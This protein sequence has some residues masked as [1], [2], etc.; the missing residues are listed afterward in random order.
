MPMH[1]CGPRLANALIALTVLCTIA[2]TADAASVEAVVP[3][4]VSSCTYA[5]T[6]GPT[7]G[8]QTMIAQGTYSIDPTTGA[9]ILNPVNWHNGS[10]TSASLGLSGNSDPVLGFSFAAG[11]GAVGDT[12]ALSLSMPIALSGEIAAQSQ[13]SYSLTATTAAGAEIQPLS[14]PNVVTAQESSSVVGGP[15]PFNKGVDVG[16]TFSF[17]SLGT[18]NSPVYSAQN[19]FALAAGNQYNLMSVTIAFTLSAN[20]NVGLS[21]FVEQTPV[22]LPPAVWLFL[23]GA[24]GIGF[25]GRSHRGLRSHR[26]YAL[27]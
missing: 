25:L 24:L 16:K 2:G 19:M 21:G 26:A 11:T 20:S 14:G 9:I 13:V 3:C 7:G 15:P 8:T 4:S 10:G 23:S 17:T 12:F 27:N 18:Q 1:V 6:E 22:P 5:I